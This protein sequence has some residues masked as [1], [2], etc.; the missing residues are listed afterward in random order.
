MSALTPDWLAWPQTRALVAA[1]AKAKIPLRF[2][3]GAVRDALLGIDVQDVD[4]A[5]PAIPDAVLALLKKAKIRAIPTGIAHGTVT[6]VIEGK[7]FEITTLRRDVATDG[8]HAEVAFTDDW[9]EDARRRD[10]TMNALY[11]SP[12]GELFDYVG[13]QVDARAGQVCFI[14]ETAARILEDYLRI[15]R[16]FRFHAHIGKGAPDEVTLAICAQFAPKI[17]ELSGERV[18]HELVKLLAAPAPQAVL[19]LMHEHKILPYALGFELRDTELF[20]RLVAIEALGGS[21]TA[22]VKLAGFI[23]SVG[24][25]MAEEEALEILNER[26]KLSKATLRDIQIIIRHQ[27]PLHPAIDETAAKKLLRKLGPQHFRHT[28]ML[29]WAAGEE[30]V[31]GTHAYMHL[32]ELAQR[33]HIPVFPVT[34]DDLKALGMEEGKELG[35]LLAELEGRWEASDYT[36]G[37]EELLKWV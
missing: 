36:L 13:G 17:A 21:L 10:F 30:P 18:Q 26:L 32:L 5:T 33:W 15:L 1:F 35:E 4:A 14:G 19:S 25:H 2:V 34:G 24:A 6:A 8:R 37:K 31:V 23:L 9:E 29:R 16:F 7:H 27:K 28:V 3:G 20:S 12:E 22:A 11:L